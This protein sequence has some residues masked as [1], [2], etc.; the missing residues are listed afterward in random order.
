[1]TNSTPSNTSSY[2]FFRRGADDGLGFGFYLSALIIF[3]FLSVKVTSLSYVFV[4]LAAGVP[5]YVYWRL[6]RSFIDSEAT[7]SFPSLWMQGITMYFCGGLVMMAAGCVYL[8]WIDPHY[9]QKLGALTV[10]ALELGDYTGA[11]VSSEEMSN[12][13]AT[14]TPLNLMLEFLWLA[15]FTGSILSMIMAWAARATK[16]YLQ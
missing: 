14:M 16:Y 12:M 8:M 4:A 15:M 10:E 6:R 13:F 2:A 1:M 7:Q 9:L 11:G 5:F 3:L